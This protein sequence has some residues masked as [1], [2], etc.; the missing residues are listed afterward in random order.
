MGEGGTGI[1]RGPLFA[2]KLDNVLIAKT[3]LNQEGW[4]PLYL[5]SSMSRGE[6]TLTVEFINDFN[7]PGRGEDRNL[8]LGDLDIITLIGGDK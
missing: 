8:F 4:A 2:V 3:F 1:G 5:S 6:H 7:D